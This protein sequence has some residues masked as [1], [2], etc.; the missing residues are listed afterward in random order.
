MELTREQIFAAADA[1]EKEGKKATIRSVR[2]FLGSGS[3]TTIQTAMK[4]RVGG[5][6]ETLSFSNPQSVTNA[7]IDTPTPSFPTSV[8]KALTNAH[9]ALEN[10][11]KIVWA[12]ALTAA[13]ERL[14]AEKEKMAAARTEAETESAKARAHA[15]KMQVERDEAIAKTAKFEILQKRLAVTEAKLEELRKAHYALG[16]KDPTALPITAAKTK[17]RGKAKAKKT[18]TK[19]KKTPTS[20]ETM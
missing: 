9:N 13:E 20:E 7:N 10:F 4:E 8:E 3:L 1:L 16:A 11:A 6:R 2:E 17:A 12:E 19:N 18:T 14:T 15:E 5:E